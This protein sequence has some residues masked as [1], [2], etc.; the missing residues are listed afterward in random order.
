MEYS[1]RGVQG[2]GA[3]IISGNSIAYEG[4]FTSGYLFWLFTRA[5]AKS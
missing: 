5:L 3:Q 2:N 1:K 4:L